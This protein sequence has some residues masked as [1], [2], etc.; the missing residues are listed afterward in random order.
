MAILPSGENMKADFVDCD[1]TEFHSCV[2]G[3]NGLARSAVQMKLAFWHRACAL[4]AVHSARRL[5]RNS[6]DTSE[7][8]DSN[9]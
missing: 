5:M 3:T 6:C 4:L 9:G 8:G 2:Y 7:P 1:A